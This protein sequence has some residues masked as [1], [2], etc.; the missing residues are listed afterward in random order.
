[1]RRV[2]EPGLVSMV[3]SN[4]NNANYI[5]ECLDSL[6]NQTYRNIEI[7]V[8]DDASTDNSVEI[9]EN[10]IRRKSS[11]DSTTRI[12]FLKLPQ[13][14]GFSGAVTAGL[15]LAN[16]EYIAMQ[17]GDDYSGGMRVEKQ[18]KYLKENAD[19][20]A[21]GT[22]YAVFTKNDEEP[23]ILPNFIEYG[24]EE[25]RERYS[26]G[27]SAV[28]YGTL[29]FKGEIFDTVGG[30]TRRM[31]GAEDAEY[32]TKLLPYGL[33]NIN[34]ALYY[35][36]EHK[37]Q[38]SREFYGVEVKNGPKVSREN[39]RVMLVLDRFD[40]GGTET[41]VL[42]LAK[43]LINQGVTVT[44][45][46]ADGPLGSEF[47]KLNCK[48]YNMEFPLIVPRDKGTI[49]IFK[50]NIKRVIEAEEINIIHGNQSPSGSLCL[51]ASKE[52]S[53]PYVFTI[54][55]MYYHDI[56]Y[57]ILPRCNSIISVSYPAYDWLLE[58]GIQSRVVPNGV[59]YD[60]FNKPSNKNSIRK[61][62]GIPEDAIVVMYCSRM[63]W[64]K[65]KVCENLIRVCR[66]LKLRENIGIHALIVGDG[67]G[68]EELKKVGDKVNTLLGE[69]I[70]HFTGNQVNLVDF[71]STC[72]CVVGTG[73][74]V[75]E[76]LAAQKTVIATGND[77]YFGLIDEE[78]F[79][80]SWKMYFGDHASHVVNNAM[81]LYDDVK[82]FFI[83]RETLKLSTSSIYE[84][85]KN[86][87]D[88][89]VVVNQVI[90][91]YLNSFI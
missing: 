49:D 70:I 76:G 25:I 63:A 19:I 41:H 8:I 87:F 37:E 55:G 47:R 77:G 1:M 67:P 58:F 33:D 72:D 21:I 81:Y 74:V 80:E 24:V 78:N 89:S 66:D 20:K 83:E 29:L 28:S 56:L 11:E 64:G 59:I 73:R 13:N 44:I 17:D 51:E 5:E 30:L 45:L 38:R 3:V 61:E 27:G 35:Y 62:Y 54:H 32:I 36:R 90:D 48:I 7:I 57:D 4:Y 85:S 42:T 26:N 2:R 88:I 12:T 43:E 82:K 50:Q 16:G 68:Y 15:Y 9:I 6:F 69:N 86:M 39:L 10:W 31:N 14:V 65:I 40:V 53:I 23:K 84:R 22:N 71:Y 34:E 91:I 60:D 79:N 52:F 46:G 75:I 18:V